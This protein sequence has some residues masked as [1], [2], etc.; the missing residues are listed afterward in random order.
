MLHQSF[1]GV[2]LC[3]CAQMLLAEWLVVFLLWGSETES[4]TKSQIEFHTFFT[5]PQMRWMDKPRLNVSEAFHRLA[6]SEGQK[7]IARRSKAVQKRQ[8]REVKTK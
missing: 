2:F 6:L 1:F 5:A 4:I 8:K 7:E 3:F